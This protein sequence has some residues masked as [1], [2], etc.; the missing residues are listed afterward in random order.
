MAQNARLA[1]DLSLNALPGGSAMRSLVVYDSTLPDLDVLLSGLQEHVIAL[2]VNPSQDAIAV[3]DSALAATHAERLVLVGHGSPGQLQLGVRPISRELIEAQAPT[4][5]SWNLK[6]VQLYACQVGVDRTLL[7]RLQELL[8]CPVAASRG[9]VGHPSRQASWDLEWTAADVCNLQPGAS[10]AIA[11]FHPRALAAWRHHL[12]TLSVGAGETYTTIQAAIDA[13]SDGDTIEV[14]A[15]TYAELLS[16]YKSITLRGPNA[17]I[18]ATGAARNPEAIL[19]FPPGATDDD[20]ILVYV[21]PNTHNVTI[22]GFTLQSDDSLISQSRIDSLIYTDKVNNL[23]ILNNELIGSTLPIYVL[24]D[25]DQS[26]YRDGLLI[27]GNHINGGANVNSDYNRGIYIQATAGTISDNLVESVNIGIQY[28]PYGNPSAGLI[29]NNTVSAAQIGLYHNY[30]NLGAAAVVWQNNTVTVAPNDQTGLKQ[31]VYGPLAA[32]VTFRGIQITT[33]GLEGTGSAPNV[34]F[35]GNTVDAELAPGQLYNTTSREAVRISTAGAASNINFQSN[36]FG[37]YNIEVINLTANIYSLPDSNVWNGENSLLLAGGSANDNLV[38]TNDNDI[39][40]AGGGSD[41]INGGDGID[42]VI[43]SGLSTDYSVSLIGT[44]IIITSLSNSADIVYLSSVE[45]AG[46]ADGDLFL[47]NVQSL[48][49]AAANVLA[50]ATSSP[51]IAIITNGDLA[52]LSTLIVDTEVNDYTITITDT[53]V[54][55]SQ[56]N[57]LHTKTSIAVDATAITT[58]T[59]QLDDVLAAYAAQN[60]GEINGLD[61]NESIVIS[62]LSASAAD[63]LGLIP[64]TTGTI[65]L[66]SLQTLT[67]LAAD[68]NAIYIAGQISGLGNEDITL[69]DTTLAA[70]LLVDSTG[71]T[72]KTTGNINASSLETLTGNAVTLASAYASAQITGLGNE[73]LTVTGVTSVADANT[74]NAYTTGVITATIA[75]GTASALKTLTGAGAGAINAYTLTINSVSVSADDLNTLNSVTSVAV[76]ATSVST[77]TGN[78]ADLITVYVAAAA[79]EISGLGNEAI[80]LA[81]VTLGASLLNALNGYTTGAVNAATVTTLTGGAAD[82]SQAY[83][84][85]TSQISGLGNEAVTLTDTTLDASVL[86]TLNGSTTGVVNAATVTTLTG[87]AAAV[88]TAYAAGAAQISGLGNEA[89]TLTDTTLAASLLNTLNS[90][91]TGVVNASS[92][93]TL[94]GLVADVTAVYAAGSAQISGLGDEAITVSG[95]ITV[96][97]ANALD[98]LTTGVVTATI[99]NTDLATLATLTGTGNAYT[100]TIATTTVDATTLNSLNARTTGVINASSVLTITGAAEDVRAV[101]A[102]GA[103]QISGLGNEAI[104]LTDTTLAASLLNTINGY[105]TGVVNASSVITLTGAAADLNS[106]YVAGAA[107]ISG[108]GNETLILT[109]TTL[110]ASLLNTLNGRTTGVVDAASLTTL[111][112]TAADVNT[113]YAAG[114]SQISGLDNKDV[115]LTDTTLAASLLNTLNGYTTGVVNAASVNIIT[116]NVADV[117]AVYTAGSAQISGLGNEAVTVS[118]SITVAQANV[119]DA[120]T[121]GVVTATISDTDP[122]IL[123]TLT[124]TGN[125]YTISISGTTIDAAVLNSLNANTSGVINASGILTI[126]GSAE[127]V[128]AAYAAGATQISGLGNETV[129]LSDTTLAASLL[130][131]LNA[132]TTG[133]VNASSVTTLTGSATDVNAVY[134]AGS[135]QISIRADAA[136]TVNSGT[137]TVVQANTIHARTTGVVTATISNTESAALVNLTGTGNAYTIT[138]APAGAGAAALLTIAGKTTI[139]INATALT[140]LSGSAADVQA[141]LASTS[142]SLRS[143]IAA[144]VSG[145]TTVAQANAI[146][147]ATTGVVTASISNTDLT[148]LLTL[149]STNNANAY[150]ITISNTTADAAVLNTINDKTSGIVNAASVLTITGAADDVRA[151]YFA[152]SGQISGLGNEAVTLSDTV[153]AATVL[154]DINGKTTGVVNAGAVLTLTGTAASVNS[155]YA[156]GAAQISGLGNEAITLTDS[157][158]TSAVLNTTDNYTSG[159]VNAASVTTLSGTLVTLATALASSGV[160]G[161]GS[162]TVVLTDTTGLLSPTTFL[163]VSASTASAYNRASNKADYRVNYTGSSGNDLFSGFGY[164]DSLSGAGGADTLIGGDGND[165]LIGGAGADVLTGSDGIDTFRLA[166]LTDSLLSGYDVITDFQIGTDVIDGPTAVASANLAKLGSVASLTETGIAAVLTASTFLASRAATFTFGSGTSTRTFLALNN[167]TAGFAAS[168]DS[169]IEITGYT[170]S[171]SNLAVS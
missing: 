143:N 4:L 89:V 39:F 80:T 14:Q 83:A 63:L 58:L 106:A 77:L 70:S 140:S 92:V 60:Q 157:S 122:A 33:F 124:G 44:P 161:L 90:R 126:T 35:I 99:S 2:Q 153:I 125:A 113:A 103:T 100:I 158:L 131:T 54:D 135:S 76:N 95:S 156:A 32:P 117:T 10:N 71:I 34:T 25:P 105:T 12:A 102:A 79:G 165:T 118:G 85:G 1:S 49:V 57:I 145:T 29:S 127:N 91:T 160:T 43:F 107:Q 120:A 46:F 138:V 64:L 167:A 121:T 9:L 6:A 97:Q 128:R 94:T 50:S 55:A 66:S 28:I 45:Y 68:V 11:P 110:A 81:D 30:Q 87:A 84:A 111:T 16:I 67:G 88:N 61:G 15:G 101:Y 147:A 155:A 47:D 130:N 51:V 18:N 36:T 78:A 168:S 159:T 166:L 170:G 112:G 142:I 38:G 5:S 146:D 53:S 132:Y 114:A 93:A 116:G 24:T 22:D 150:A 3:I 148:T 19:T 163:A 31:N 56:L 136:V 75:T 72:T 48:T 96:A 59:G 73:A 17:G 129:I 13:S 42:K 41:T 137:I 164:S 134:A 149:T 115:T 104:T 21:E 144:S 27:Q 171:L 62:G 154:N 169:I 141:V 74:L 52:T 65:N 69:T 82:V 26:V 20:S 86:N 40:F 123:A 109:D 7:R 133:V 151:A 98:A 119:I 37:N 152:G 139:P 8:R 23:S 162:T 108:L